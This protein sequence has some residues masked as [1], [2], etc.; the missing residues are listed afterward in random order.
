MVDGDFVK[1]VQIGGPE[2]HDASVKDPIDMVAKLDERLKTRVTLSAGSHDIA[3]TWRERPFIRQDVW[4]VSQR[5]SQEVHLAGG[6]PR[7]RTVSV[8]GP[9]KVTGVSDTP[10]RSRLFVCR[11]ASAA[12]EPACAER[13]LSTLARR[14]L[15]RTLTRVDID[16]PLTFL[17]AT[18][19]E[20]G[21]FDDGCRS[22]ASRGSSRARRSSIA[23]SAIQAGLRPASPHRCS[24]TGARI[25]VV[26][27]PVEQHPGSAADD[28]GRLRPAPRSGRPQRASA[29]DD[30]PTRARYA[31]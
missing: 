15:R 23:W 24:D 1:T 3:V 19:E 4:E 18:R 29:T 30:R 11:P 25:A 17:Q 12:E 5:D 8:A 6:L 14:A 28:I 20:G 27:L 7:L 10:S 22:P 9:F 2:D 13:I 26:V 21:S 31:W 16:A